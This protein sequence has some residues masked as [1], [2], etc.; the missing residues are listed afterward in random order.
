[1]RELCDDTLAII[2]HGCIFY[3]KFQLQL[4]LVTSHD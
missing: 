1:M 3:Q 2:Q 4:C